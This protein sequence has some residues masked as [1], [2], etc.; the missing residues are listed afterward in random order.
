M[1]AKR[2]WLSSIE[3]VRDVPAGNRLRWIYPTQALDAGGRFLGLPQTLVVERA[4]LDRSQA[5]RRSEPPSAYVPP[6]FWDSVGTVSVKSLLPPIV[7][8]LSGPVQAA[9]FSYQGLPA[10]LYV[11]DTETGDVVAQR[12]VADGDFVVIEAPLFDQ[13]EFETFS[14]V[15]L[16]SLTTLDLFKDPGLPWEGIAE[17]DV[18]A[19]LTAAFTAVAQRYASPPTLSSSDWSR[20]VDLANL[21][22]AAKPGD[23][24]AGTGSLPPETFHGVT[25][26]QIFELAL[27]AR[28]E[29]ALLFGSAF[30]DGPRSQTSTLDRIARTHLLDQDN[31][32]HYRPFDFAYRVREKHDRGVPPSNIAVCK[33]QLASP[34]IP[35]ISASYA[36]ADVRLKYEA[37]LEGMVPTEQF[38]ATVVLRWQ[39]GDARAIGVE[40][41]E[42]IGNSLTLGTPATS[43]EFASRTRDAGQ[44]AT[45]TLTRTLDVPFHDV[46]LRA[47]V[48]AVDGW[49]RVSDPGP[50][51]ATAL[52]L[53]H[54]PPAPPLLSAWYDE[55]T[56][57]THIPRAIGTPPFPSW[58]PDIVVQRASGNVVIYRQTTQPA[59][60]SVTVASVFPF[61]VPGQFMVIPSPSIANPSDYQ[62]GYLASGS[63]KAQIELITAS[64]ILVAVPERGDG[65]YVVFNPGP[66]LLQQDPQNVALWSPVTTLPAAGLPAELVFADPLPRPTDSAA[67]LSYQARIEFLARVGPPSNVVQALRLPVIPTVPPPFEV[68]LLGVDFYNRTMVKIWF[69]GHVPSGFCTVWWAKGQIADTSAFADRA[70]PGLYRAQPV[71]VSDSK[72]YLFDVLALPLPRVHDRIITIGVQSVNLAGGQSDFC[73]VPAV[74]PTPV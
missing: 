46:I 12:T 13:L 47:Q 17:I 35:P 5:F 22:Q 24:I 74:I 45:A 50:V 27:G 37:G 52:T 14:G 59:T 73:L 8:K 29:Y 40:V 1:T 41:N 3:W 23:A 51:T 38:A 7:Y 33:A 4:Q 39:Q 54:S 43:Q 15:T 66:A 71:F 57:Q 65:Q 31:P 55:S 64:Q 21:A 10:T 53:Q 44:A 16:L 32:A 34:L 9:K 62:G 56:G 36:G 63:V 11:R 49:D 19:T 61:G 68:T 25:T 72:A 2:I 42:Q 58:D 26:W 28:W 60:Q 30:F 20:L 6:A 70:V 18:A 48:R 67:V 69:T